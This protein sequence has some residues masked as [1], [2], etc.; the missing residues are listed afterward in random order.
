MGKKKTRYLLETDANS[1]KQWIAWDKVAFSYYLRRKW[2]IFLLVSES[3]AFK[4]LLWICKILNIENHA[5]DENSIPYD[6]LED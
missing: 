2:A 6:I 5:K 1:L 4:A 3:V